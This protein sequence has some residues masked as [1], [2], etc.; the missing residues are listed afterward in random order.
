[1][2]P[3]ESSRNDFAARFASFWTAPSGSRLAELF[4]SDA[5]IH[6]PGAPPMSVGSYVAHMDAM[7]AAWPDLQVDVSEFA[8]RDAV[9]FIS[10]EARATVQGRPL[11][12]MGVD[13]FRLRAGMAIEEH[14]VFDR[15]ALRE[16][17]APGPRDPEARGLA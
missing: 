17:S 10:W 11:Q 13:R 7:L 16:P 9:V 1:M 3:V 2:K 12:W 5:V 4:R 15:L 8:T 14:V 6:W